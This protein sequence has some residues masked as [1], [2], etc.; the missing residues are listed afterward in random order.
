MAIKIKNKSGVRFILRIEY[1]PFV[2]HGV[3]TNICREPFFDEEGEI[4]LSQLND[5]CGA[6]YITLTPFH[7]TEII[8]SN[9]V[10]ELPSYVHTIQDEDRTGCS[11][12]TLERNER[13]KFE[14]KYSE[15]ERN[16][17]SFKIQV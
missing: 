11:V 16:D 4:Q 15:T 7:T 2:D 17:D 1:N 3:D 6:D 12:I 9:P 5:F 10:H 8:S 14:F 13:G